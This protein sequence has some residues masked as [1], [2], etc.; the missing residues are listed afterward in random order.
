MTWLWLKRRQGPPKTNYM[1]EAL[2]CLANA[3]PDKDFDHHY[4]LSTNMLEW[5][6][7]LGSHVDCLISEVDQAR[8]QSRAMV[9]ALLHCILSYVSYD[10][11]EL[12]GD[13]LGP[14]N[15]PNWSPYWWASFTG[16]FHV[17]EDL[18]KTLN[19]PPALWIQAMVMLFDQVRLECRNNGYDLFHVLR[20]INFAGATWTQIVEKVRGIPISQP[21]FYYG[22]TEQPIMP[23]DDWIQLEQNSAFYNRSSDSSTKF[24]VMPIKAA[25]NAPDNALFNGWVGKFGEQTLVLSLEQST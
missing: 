4:G 17:I 18:V 19:C 14:R 13:Q 2:F 20:H 16:S 22:D 6:R 1:M 5:Q 23:L 25:F 3:C 11:R 12:D 24:F 21:P 15:S 9:E 10:L 7:I 8:Q